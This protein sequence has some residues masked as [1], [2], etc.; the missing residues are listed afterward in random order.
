MSKKY[1]GN[2]VQSLSGGS[3][4]GGGGDTGVG[5][6]YP[7]STGGEYFN[8]YGDDANKNTASGDYST[9]IGQKCTASGNYSFAGGNNVTASGNYSF[10]FGNNNVARLYGIAIGY[11]NEAK[12]RSVSI[13]YDNYRNYAPNDDDLILVGRGL[14]SYAFDVTS[15]KGR[16]IFGSYNEI[17]SYLPYGYLVLGCGFGENGRKT[18]LEADSSGLVRIPHGLC[19]DSNTTIANAITA[20]QDSSNVTTDDQTLATKSYV[21]ANSGSGGVGEAYPGSTGGEIFNYYGTDSNANVASGD[22]STARGYKCQAVGK[23]SFA[24]GKNCTARQE[25]EIAIGD[26]CKTGS[27]SGYSIAIGKNCDAQKNNIAIG[28]NVTAAYPGGSQNYGGT[29]AFGRNINAG[30]VCVGNYLNGG[31]G[32]GSVLIGN[33]LT[34]ASYSTYRETFAPVYIGRNPEADSFSPSILK[35]GI[36]TQGGVSGG[37]PKTVLESDN[38]GLVRLPHGLCLD[39]INTSVNAITPPQDPNNVTAD[40]QTLATKS[41]VDTN[42]G[43]G[44]VGQAYSGSTGGEIFN[45]Y[46]SDADANQA[47]GDYS[48]TKG[49]HNI[50]R[51]NCSFVA[52]HDN[53]CATPY[54]ETSNSGGIIL[55]NNNNCQPIAGN[56]MGICIG[57]DNSFFQGEGQICIG[58]NNLMK[59]MVKTNAIVIGQYNEG[60][61][62]CVQVG[63][64]GDSP[65]LNANATKFVVGCGSGSN[66]RKNA[67]ECSSGSTSLTGNNNPITLIKYNFGLNNATSTNKAFV[68]AITPPQDPQNVTAD[69]QTLVTKSYLTSQIPSLTPYSKSQV[70]YFEEWDNATILPID[71]SSISLTTFGT[72]PTWSNRAI[73][74][75]RWENEL[76]T[77]EVFFNKNEGIHLHVV[78]RAYSAFPETINYKHMRIEW[79]YTNSNFTAADF[80]TY[81]QDMNNAGAISNWSHTL[82]NATTCKIL[83]VVFSE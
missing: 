57:H 2:L 59:N 4:G 82:S 52:G 75:F 14:R 40:D 56:N 46:G 55:G 38:N 13:G 18:A 77:K 37:T 41:Y 31:V 9:A 10:A 16:W 69:D 83:S 39:N 54:G 3:G 43:S 66:N 72:I 35:I 81:D 21:D 50:T 22:Y 12:L 17:T 25:G 24:S 49:K 28:A 34:T 80:W 67:I 47:I 51:G 20:P 48:T 32:D 5:K 68:N 26:N 1:I 30:G 7:G 73:I 23:Y 76:I 63:M 19:L 27:Y 53:S 33:N 11:K 60:I 36:G 62:N 61:K 15:A 58:A 79:N 78:Q 44:G 8:Y 74:T 64:Y 65:T 29:T 45:Y 70:A 6:P 42:S 71:G